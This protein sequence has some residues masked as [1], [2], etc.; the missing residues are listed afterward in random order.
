MLV[1]D[2]TSARSGAKAS[3]GTSRDSHRR[4]AAGE[5]RRSATRWS[6]SNRFLV[7]RKRV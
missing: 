4:A 3:S 1:H 2:I 6:A 7:S 5:I